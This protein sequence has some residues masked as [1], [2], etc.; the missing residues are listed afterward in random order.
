[1]VENGQRK[2]KSDAYRLRRPFALSAP[3]LLCRPCQ[4]SLEVRWKEEIHAVEGFGNIGSGVLYGG[5]DGK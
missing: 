1:M 5:L 4:D 2:A 3:R